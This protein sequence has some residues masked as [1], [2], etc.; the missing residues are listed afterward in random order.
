MLASFPAS[1][2]NQNRID[3]GIP[4]RFKLTPSRFSP[5]E[6][7]LFDRS[8]KHHV[9]RFGNDHIENY[10]A[11]AYFGPVYGIPPLYWSP[12]VLLPRFS[13]RRCNQVRQTAELVR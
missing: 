7:L 8:A 11:R 5:Y 3:L 6:G 1:M 9:V 2:V 12:R 13:A 4:N 10:A